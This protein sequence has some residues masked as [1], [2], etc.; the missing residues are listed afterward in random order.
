MK[1]FLFLL[2]PGLVVFWAV[3]AAATPT[4]IDRIEAS[5]N[6]GLILLSDVGRFRKTLGL[7]AQLDPLFAGTSVASQGVKASSTDIVQ[8]LIDERLISSQFP[9]K[10]D[11][12]EQEV[13]SIVANNHISREQLKAT[14]LEQGYAFDDYFDLIRSSSAKRNLIDRDIR[15]KVTITDDDVKN[16]FYNHYAKSANTPLSYKIKLIVLT[17]SN[18]KTPAAAKDTAD[19]ALKAV[20]GG[21]AFEEVARRSSDDGSASTGGELPVLSDDQMSPVVREQVKKLKVGEVSDVFG[22]PKTAYFVMKLIDV[23]SGENGRFE[24]MKDEIRAQLAASEYQRQIGLWIERQ[25]QSAFIHM[26]GQPSTSGIPGT[27]SP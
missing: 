27:R 6:S 7:R 24:K 12:V 26:A 21:E 13:N 2:V 11:E 15:T 17:V 23:V 16:Y 19:R 20:R 1:R 14:L 22:S 9:V 8:F 10:D 3:T 25:R 5:V 18:Y 4:V